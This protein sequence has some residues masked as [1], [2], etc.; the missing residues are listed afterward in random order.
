[1]RGPHQGAMASYD[2]TNEDLTGIELSSYV[3]SKLSKG[4]FERLPFTVK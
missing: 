4:K 1:M 2:F 3:F